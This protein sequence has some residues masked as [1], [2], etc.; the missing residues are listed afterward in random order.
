MEHFYVTLPSN[1]SFQYYG[2]QSMSNYKT[3]LA[4]DIHLNVDEWEVG[5]AE[6]IY[7]ISWHNVMKGLFTVRKLV[8]RKWET[9]H[10]RIPDN[11]YDSVK[12]LLDILK[13]EVNEILGEQSGKINFSY[14]GTRHVK[15]YLSDGYA[16][17]LSPSLSEALGFG[18][19][20]N[21]CEL[22]NHK[23][24]SRFA[25]TCEVKKTDDDNTLLSP[26]IADVNRGMRSLFIHCNIVTAQLV[27]DMY[28]PLLRTVAVKGNTGDVVAKSF[29]NIHYM[30][31]ERSNFQEIEI[32]ITDET[33]RTVPFQQGRV[34]VKLHF[35]RK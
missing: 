12:S 9:V 5:L 1:S 11:R 6:F 14:I 21:I 15:V 13:H 33:G 19:Y 23:T 18:D 34:I 31:I 20:D 35:K 25:E 3:K 22:R 27:G 8:D 24:H 16:I 10:G 32:H 26:F 29:S 2:K 4:K 30:S 17:R 28:V 7:P